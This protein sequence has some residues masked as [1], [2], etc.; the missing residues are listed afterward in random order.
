MDE[1]EI[2]ILEELK[3]GKSLKEAAESASTKEIV[4]KRWI[5]W[6]KDGDESYIEFYNEYKKIKP[7]K[8]KSVKKSPEE[9]V[10]ECVELL[11]NGDD[12]KEISHKLNIPEFRLRNFYSQ[13]KLGIKPYDKYYKA[14]E[15][16][17]K[18]KKGKK[19]ESNIF[20]KLSKLDLKELDYILEDNNCFLLIPNK[21]IKIKTIKEEIP[22]EDIEESLEKLAEI[23]IIEDKI[24]KQL[25][26]FSVKSLLKYLSPRDSILYIN[27]PRKK[28]TKKIIKDLKFSEMEEFY[29]SLFEVRPVEI[30][31]GK[32]DIQLDITRLIEE[33]KNKKC[34]I[35]GK[36][37]NPLSKKDKCKT[38]LRSIHAAN[39]LNELLNYIQPKIPFYKEDLQKIGYQNDKLLD[40]VWVLQENDLLIVESTNKYSLV[41]KEI[42]DEFLDKWGEYVQNKRKID[43]STKLSK[44]CVICK[45]TKA[46]S[47][48]N[49]SASSVDGFKD[50]CKD[51]ER[52]VNAAKSL[53][54][55]LN[56]VGPKEVFRKEDMYSNYPEPFLLD[57]SIFLL[58]EHDLIETNP[59]GERFRLTDKKIL[60]DF[61]EKYYIEEGER[62]KIPI[63][64]SPQPIIE[65]EEDV[66][67]EPV[68]E[69]EE[70]VD[71]LDEPM[72]EEEEVLEEEFKEPEEEESSDID[73]DS[74][75]RRKMDIVLYYLKDGFTEK[76]AF[77]YA[78]LN[79]STLITWKNLGKK[80]NEPY[81]YFY[82]EYMKLNNPDSLEE[83]SQE[84]KETKEKMD[85]FT[86][87]I[88]VTGSV[89]TA[90]NNSEI[91]KEEFIAWI[92]LGNSGETFYKN[93]IDQYL[94]SLRYV[95]NEE[96]RTLRIKEAKKLMIQGYDIEE[97]AEHANK[98]DFS[99]KEKEIEEK[100]TKEVD[101]LVN[102]VVVEPTNTEKY[103][104]KFKIISKDPNTGLLTLQIIG[105]VRNEH[106]EQIVGILKDYPREIDKI[107]TKDSE[108]NSCDILIEMQIENTELQ[109]IRSLLN[110]FS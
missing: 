90:F 13:G 84:Q 27:K 11:K 51:C 20:K 99:K 54:T 48:F 52:P 94:N 61:L 72:E 71:E 49:K 83:E 70:F 2:E 40:T 68:G 25:N 60:D 30:Y 81:A 5:Q 12:Y 1:K 10:D 32:E 96:I 14:S 74:E 8:Q 46:I 62:P 59:D 24:I 80:G 103:G 55:L 4:V 44:E 41:R 9:I 23:K 82:T 107:L 65:E 45:E 29:E 58:Q 17:K 98:I 18:G 34:V 76:E 35:C 86:E 102:E 108:D 43:T 31:E 67:E 33:T 93:F 66:A 26:K 19:E 63:K 7:K 53:K 105:K 47:L 37:L 15:E 69:E 42:L 21:N 110:E 91:T 64:T 104:L 22:P 79:K 109:D 88:I 16:A 77:N 78:D 28:I 6:G 97:A 3:K 92:K 57:S 101:D 36:N 100:L 85:F 75:L 38:C 39:T 106:L 50:Y 89:K 56:Y 73:E 87:E 95:I